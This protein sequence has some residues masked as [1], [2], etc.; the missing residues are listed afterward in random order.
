M[1]ELAAPNWTTSERPGSAPGFRAPSGARDTQAWQ[2]MLLHQFRER[3]SQSPLPARPIQ[4]A[5]IAPDCPK[6]PRQGGF[7]LAVIRKLA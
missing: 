5:N 2:T 4:Q 3:L 1:G 6:R 7:L